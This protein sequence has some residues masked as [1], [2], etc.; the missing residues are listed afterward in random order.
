MLVDLEAVYAGA[1]CLLDKTQRHSNF[2]DMKGRRH[3]MNDQTR[4]HYRRCYAAKTRRYV[5]NARV[6]VS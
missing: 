3:T 6:Q 1:V 4:P 2:S 5:A